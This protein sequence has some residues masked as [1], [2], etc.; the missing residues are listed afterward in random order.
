M[1]RT[2][3]VIGIHGMATAITRRMIITTD[4]VIT[5]M[6]IPG[7]ASM[8]AS[9]AMVVTGSMDMAAITP[10]ITTRQITEV[11]GV[12]MA[13]AVAQRAGAGCWQPTQEGRVRSLHQ[14]GLL[15]EAPGQ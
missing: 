12:P 4:T 11:M 14:A 13:P 15:P 1:I 6:D 7:M 8:P 9:A 5:G 3:Q 10:L 2:T